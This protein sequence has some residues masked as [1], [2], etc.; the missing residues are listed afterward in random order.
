V[1][2][3]SDMRLTVSLQNKFCGDIIKLYTPR[4]F[5]S[6]LI[7]CRTVSAGPTVPHVRYFF[8]EFRRVLDELQKGSNYVWY[9]DPY[10]ELRYHPKGMANA[11]FDIDNAVPTGYLSLT[12]DDSQGK[13]YNKLYAKA[14]A[15]VA[16]DEVTLLFVA[17]NAGEIAL[18]AA[19][20][21]GSGIYEHYED[22]ATVRSPEH[23]VWMVEG[24]VADAIEQGVDVRYSTRG[25]GLRPGMMQHITHTDY[26][27]DG[28][29]IITETTFSLDG[30]VDPQYEVLATSARRTKP[31]INLLDNAL[32]S[33][34]NF[35]N[36]LITSYLQ[37][38][39]IGEDEVAII[40]D[41][42]DI[43]HGA[44]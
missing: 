31:L 12:C 25:A 30:G 23:G 40:A 32:E 22:L 42:L 16:G 39:S 19:A 34:S 44:I 27:I 35:R 37:T 33:K 17:E 3:R 4:L 15:V 38:G 41:S 24:M 43:T 6:D 21:G 9:I 5:E 10:K 26:G 18:R 28:D 8:T 29:F 14:K 11:P 13:Y 2:F 1:L 7:G 20:E 36:D